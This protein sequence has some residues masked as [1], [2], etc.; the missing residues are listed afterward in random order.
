MTTKRNELRALWSCGVRNWQVWVFREELKWKR[1]LR[2]SSSSIK[3]LIRVS[4]RWLMSN[5]CVKESCE[6]RSK[7]DVGHW[8]SRSAKTEDTCGDADWNRN[9]CMD[10]GMKQKGTIDSDWADGAEQIC[11]RIWDDW[12]RE[13][14]VMIQW[15]EV[16]VNK[17]ERLA[18]MRQIR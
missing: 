7:T 11:G 16:S 3:W 12:W 14:E 4:K 8:S 5:W 1:N 9:D 13:K 17:I 6:E 10:D 18:W 2:L 15:W